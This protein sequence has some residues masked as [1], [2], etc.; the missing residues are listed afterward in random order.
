[1]SRNE[2]EERIFALM[3]EIGQIARAY[4]GTM[5]LNLSIGEEEISFFS[6]EGA[7]GVRALN[8]TRFAN[9]RVYHWDEM[10]G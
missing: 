10:E 4:A 2:C 9:G 8:A 5:E 6:P 3:E 1:M 7:D